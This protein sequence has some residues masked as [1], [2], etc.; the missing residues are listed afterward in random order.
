MSIRCANPNCAS[1]LGP[2]DL[3]CGD[4]GTRRPAEGVT[5]SRDV[6][7]NS[8][9]QQRAS[10]GSALVTTVSLI[11]VAAA[12]YFLWQSS[13]DKP[14][15]Q[16]S[17]ATSGQLSEDSQQDPEIVHG[18]PPSSGDV[19]AGDIPT[20]TYQRLENSDGSVVYQLGPGGEGL[21]QALAEDLKSFLD[22]NR[23]G[24]ISKTEFFDR[25]RDG[26]VTPEEVYDQDE[27]G[28]VSPAERDLNHDGNVDQRDQLDR[29]GDGVLSEA[30]LTDPSNATMD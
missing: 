21:P 2:E 10:T 17:T 1:V 30:E 23:D 15:Q 4:C 29:D 12:G 28:K 25:N 14:V 20:T 18:L 5:F 3:F 7:A 8:G 26:M 9:E 16:G 11:L 6:A 22:Q 27:D 24:A 19:P 13:Q